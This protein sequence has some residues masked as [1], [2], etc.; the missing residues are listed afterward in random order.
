ML[1][2]TSMDLLIYTSA[3]ILYVILYSFLRSSDIQIGYFFTT[4]NLQNSLLKSFL[5]SLGKSV[6]YA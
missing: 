2:E 4:L 3:F 1:E 6:F 5:F